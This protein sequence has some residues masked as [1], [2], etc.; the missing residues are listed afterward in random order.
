MHLCCFV[1][2]LHACRPYFYLSFGS[3]CPSSFFSQHNII[4]DTFL[5]GDWAGACQIAEIAMPFAVLS[6]VMVY[7]C[8][9]VFM[10][11]AGP[12]GNV[13]SSGGCATSTGVSTCEAYA[14][15]YPSA[16]SEAYWEIN[17]ILVRSHSP[18]SVDRVR[19]PLSCVRC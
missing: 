6:Y 19:F 10:W 17:S 16:F 3:N 4:V 12:V 15:G 18:L 7:G 1:R 11:S 14:Q 9:H 5:C 8:V 2:V 13:W